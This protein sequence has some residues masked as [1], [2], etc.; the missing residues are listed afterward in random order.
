MI[1]ERQCCLV[2]KA[3]HRA[4]P[5]VISTFESHDQQ[6]SA[7]KPAFLIS[8]I[9]MTTPVPTIIDLKTAFLRAQITSLSQP[10]IPTP[11]WQDASQ[12]DDAQHALRQKAVDEALYKLNALIKQH[13]KRAYSA[14]AVRHVAEQIDAL[15]WGSAERDVHPVE[16]GL[17]V[18]TDYR[19]P[20]FGREMRHVVIT[21]S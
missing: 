21:G 19:E 8:S 3:P 17:E 18:G 14:P 1:S 10:I 2:R 9:T 6:Y 20:I 4:S 5:C 15:Y 7:F 12:P 13:N 11:G 16:E